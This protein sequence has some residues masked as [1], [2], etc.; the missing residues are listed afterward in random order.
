ELPR[1]QI[2]RMMGV[3]QPPNNDA[4]FRVK[5]GSDRLLEARL[6]SSID[7]RNKDGVNW[8]DPILNQGNCG[9]CVAFSTIGTLQTQLNISSGIPGL[10]EQFSTQA[11]FACGGGACDFGWEPQLAAQYLQTTGVP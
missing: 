10:D 4:L 7:W 5:E 6:P 1:E 2:T 3:Q 9:S 11:L 8:V